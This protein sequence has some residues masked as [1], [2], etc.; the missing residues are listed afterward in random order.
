MCRIK[1]PTLWVKVMQSLVD[2]LGVEHHVCTSYIHYPN[3][4]VE[5]ICK[6]VLQAFRTLVSE[7]KWAKEDWVYLLPT[8]E[9]YLN[10][11]PQK[12]LAGKAPVTVMT[13]RNR[14][15]PLDV[16]FKKDHVPIVGVDKLSTQRMS[17]IMEELADQLETLH[18]DISQMTEQQRARHRHNASAKRRAINFGVGDYVLI[19]RNVRKVNAKLYLT[20]RGPF[21]VVATER[22]YVFKVKDI[23]TGE[24]IVVHG[25]RMRFYSHDTLEVTEEIKAQK[26]FD[27]T[28]WIVEKILDIRDDNG[29]PSVL[30]QW[31]GF[32]EA[33]NSWEPLQVIRED[34]PALVAAFERQRNQE[35]LRTQRP[36]A[37]PQVSKKRKVR[38]G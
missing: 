6:L 31:R 22:G 37:Q 21:Q 4:T 11:K 36:Q 15:N 7:L 25:E 3:G 32:T 23:I 35:L 8:V 13:G 18:K 20:W 14:D 38:G 34:V 24:E 29:V 16:I 17:D 30:V 12:R 28:T 27:D 2:R 5:V 26:A 19:A 33:E 1:P 10:H 9:Y